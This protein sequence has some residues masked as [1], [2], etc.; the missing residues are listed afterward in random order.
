MI[1]INVRAVTYLHIRVRLLREACWRGGRHR[2]TCGSHVVKL[3]T[4]EEWPNV[5]RQSPDG[6]TCAPLLRR[7]SARTATSHDAI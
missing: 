5:F 4:S 7:R 2:S 3:S 1:I 6:S